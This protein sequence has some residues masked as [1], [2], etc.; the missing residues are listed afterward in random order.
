MVDFEVIKKL[1]IE[2]DSKIVLLVIDGLGGLPLPKSGKTELETASTTHLDALAAQSICG[3]MDPISPGITP[4]S[5]PAH[6][7]LFGYPPLKYEVGRGVL[8]ALGIGFPLQ[9]SDVAARINFATKNQ[10]GLIIDRRA[11]RLSSDKGAELCKILD[12]IKLP[13]IEIFVRP[14]KE[15]RSVLVLRGRDLSGELTDSDPQQI[16]LLP[17]SVQAINSDAEKTALLA[18]QFI[19]EANKALSN[20]NSGNAILCRGFDSYNRFPSMSEVFKLKAACIANY[21]M[22]KGVARLVGMEILQTGEKIEEE[23]KTLK[24]NYNDFDFFYL[25]IKKTDSAGEDGNFELKA[26]LIEEVDKYVPKLLELEPE[27]I[28]V[29][30]DHSTPALLKLHS[31]HPLPVLIY[32][33]WC[34]PDCVKNFSE[35]ACIQGGLGRMLSVEIIPLALAHALRL[36]KYGA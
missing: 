36:K 17:L 30:G 7:A 32:S 28:I 22:Y 34:R 20:R 33:K 14:V 5:G 13:G 18:N 15:Y 23:F 11:G 8:A 21:P 1:S 29:T 16:N 6:L 35:R 27:V 2:N 12:K 4:G 19:E 9:E 31:W 25:H 10:E 3:L 26:K 24:Q